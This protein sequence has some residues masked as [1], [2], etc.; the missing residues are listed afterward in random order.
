MKTDY[1]HSE[2]TEK[3][4][5]AAYKVYNTLGFGFVEKVYENALAIELKRAGLSVTQQ[6][7]LKV[8][9]QGL[10]VGEYLAD[11]IVDGKVILEIK[12]TSGLVKA[13]EA[14]LVNYLKATSIEIGLCSVEKPLT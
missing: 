2:L 8:T 6:A 9:Y 3:T 10:V 13:Q 14:Q 1:K 7:P 4:I 5:G 11:L 12:A